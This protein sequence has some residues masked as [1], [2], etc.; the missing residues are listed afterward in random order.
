M[1]GNPMSR[2]FIRERR[3][4]VQCWGASHMKTGQSS[5]VT[6]QGTLWPPKVGKD[7][8]ATSVLLSVWLCHVCAFGNPGLQNWPPHLWVIFIDSHMAL[9]WDIYPLI[10]YER[11][12]LYHTVCP[13]VLTSELSSGL[14][15]TDCILFYKMSAFSLSFLG[16]IVWGCFLGRVNVN[17]GI[18][19]SLSLIN[20][21][22]AALAWIGQRKLKILFCCAV[23]RWAACVFPMHT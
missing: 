20:A 5:V 8:D 23:F 1:L 11:V 6:I 16:W 19:L 2:V 15:S 12:F 17:L 22:I 21:H 9:S 3:R 10:Y 14:V 7:K 4:K 13:T 18:W